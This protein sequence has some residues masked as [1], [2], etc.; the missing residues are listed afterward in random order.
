MAEQSAIKKAY[1]LLVEEYDKDFKAAGY[2]MDW[3]PN[4]QLFWLIEK[5]KETFDIN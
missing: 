1:N 3:C 4:E 2:P 5:M